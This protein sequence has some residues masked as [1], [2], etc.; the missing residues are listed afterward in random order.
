MLIESIRAQLDKQVSPP[1]LIWITSEEMCVRIYNQRLPGAAAVPKH[2]C[3]NLHTH[4][5]SQLVVPRGCTLFSCFST[6]SLS[7]TTATV[8]CFSF[9]RPFP[10]PSP[11]SLHLA[12]EII[13]GMF[14]N[15]AVTCS[16]LPWSLNLKT[17]R[18]SPSA[19]AAAGRD[20]CH[21]LLPRL[22]HSLPFFNQHWIDSYSPSA[23]PDT[24]FSLNWMSKTISRLVCKQ[25]YMNINKTA[26]MLMLI[27]S[28]WL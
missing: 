16:F 20:N 21:R 8:F 24:N 22:D 1:A 10:P 17:Q 23:R 26:S 6:F 27:H 18:F 3:P 13:H 28:L 9:S 14:G 11:S 25:K 15:P 5:Y 7:L 2:L 19:W 12:G 4:F